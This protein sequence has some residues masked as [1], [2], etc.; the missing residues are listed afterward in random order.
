MEIQYK[1]LLAGK[2]I[3]Y[4]H[5]E[6]GDPPMGVV[7]GK[8]ILPDAESDYDF[9]RNY[10][11]EKHIELHDDTDIGFI[12]TAII[13]NLIIQLPAGE[14]IPGPG[15]FIDGGLN[16]LNINLRE[17]PSPFYETEFP[18]HVQRYNEMFE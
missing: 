10:C 9:V 18:H 8:L 2:E 14:A 13:P 3:G 15:A 6:Y 16:E 11:L 4:T 7:H 17:V 5:L 12:S 1:V